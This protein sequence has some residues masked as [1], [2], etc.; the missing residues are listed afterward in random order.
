MIFCFFFKALFP[1]CIIQ[2]IRLE[3]LEKIRKL[4]IFLPML[5]KIHEKIV[6]L[7]KYNKYKRKK[8]ILIF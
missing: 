5:C 6:A 3:K 2:K 8:Q 1:F 7:Y 4:V